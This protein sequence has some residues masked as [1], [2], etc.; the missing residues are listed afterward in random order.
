MLFSGIKAFQVG[1][2]HFIAFCQLGLHVLFA[3]VKEKSRA[4]TDVFILTHHSV[5]CQ[6]HQ[7]FDQVAFII[8]SSQVFHHHFQGVAWI[9]TKVRLD[10]RLD[11]FQK[12]QQLPGIFLIFQ[13]TVDPPAKFGDQHFI[14]VFMQVVLG[15][16][17]IPL[18]INAISLRVQHVVIFQQMLS[19]IKVC[20]F[21]T[22]LRLFHQ[23][24]DQGYL[25]RHVF[26]DLEARQQPFHL[27]P[28][29]HSHQF[30]IQRQVKA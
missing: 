8:W 20:A 27:L 13:T 29:E 2:Q 4:F 15:K 9:T 17:L 19:H 18:A 10:G 6:R 22:G 14:Y 1:I 23:L 26:V 5:F 28:A 30:V 11:I 21:H 25:D 3:A 12:A 24:I 7:L 16:Y